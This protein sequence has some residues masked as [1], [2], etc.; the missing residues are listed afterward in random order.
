[1]NHL[2]KDLKKFQTPKLNPIELHKLKNKKQKKILEQLHAQRKILK[3]H[4]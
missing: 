3:P 1:M 2:K 4:N